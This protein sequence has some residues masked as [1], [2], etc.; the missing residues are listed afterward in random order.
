MLRTKI[1][2]ALFIGVLLV[3]AGVIYAGQGGNPKP[4]RNEGTHHI[5]LIVKTKNQKN[6]AISYIVGIERGDETMRSTPWTRTARGKAG[7]AVIVV[8]QPVQSAPD[9]AETTCIIEID[10]KQVLGTGTQTSNGTTGVTCT[11]QV[12]FP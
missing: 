6:T 2:A 3:A 11:T 8:A 12:P 4:Q 9:K 10:K 1:R 7:D 5:K